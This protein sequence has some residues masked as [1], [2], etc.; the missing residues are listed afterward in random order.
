[1]EPLYEGIYRQ[2]VSGRWR[3]VKG[4]GKSSTLAA[5]LLLAAVVVGQ[6]CTSDASAEVCRFAGTT[7]YAGHVAITTNVEATG[8]VTNVDVGL[9]FDATRMLGLRIHYLVEEISSWRAGEMESVAMNTRYLIGDHIVRQQWDVF[10]RGS[11][12]GLLAHRAQAKTLVDFRL[13]HPGFAQHW[14]PATFGS[15]WLQDYPLASPERRADLDLKALPLSSAL[16]TPLAMAFYWIRWL[17]QGGRDV[18]VFLPGFKADK[19]VDVPIGAA[20]SSGGLLWQA[21]LRYPALS[22]VPAS[23]ATARTSSDGHLLLLA[24]ELHEPGGSASGLIHEEGCQ[25]VPLKPADQER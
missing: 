13:R 12:G 24:F 8:G 23:T 21:V 5:K 10:Q 14:D 18:P 3:I 9:V 11:D 16:R 17:P 4:S 2:D 20:S 6:L 1:V 15:P 19:L 25:G 7:N 22:E